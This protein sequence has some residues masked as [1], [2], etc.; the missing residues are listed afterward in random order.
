[1][2]EIESNIPVYPSATSKPQLEYAELRDVIDL[3]L[4][5]GQLMLQHGAES[6]RVEE[7][8][9]RVGTALGGDWLDILISP[10]AIAITTSSGGEFRTKLRRV[11]GLY[12]DYTRVDALNQLARQVE[13]KA[14]DRFAV[15]RELERI[16]ALP[17]RYPL[18]L[19]I[20]LVGLACGAF[21][22]LFGGGWPELALTWGAASAAMAVRLTLLHLRF[23]AVLVT[24]VTAFTAGVLVIISG[25][26]LPGAVLPIALVS[27]V[28]LLVPGVQL[29]NS[30]EDMIEGYVLIGVARGAAGGLVLLGLAL[31]LLIAMQLLGVGGL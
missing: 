21:S 24:S 10:T 1:M 20:V 4:W 28:L 5:L 30:L 25:Q 31:G 17:T 15:R 29:V 27:A 14:L 8:V 26:W 3:S 12:V 13:S 23:N 18:I 6:A 7:T 2:T 9:H 11:V 19:R 22:Q 16:T